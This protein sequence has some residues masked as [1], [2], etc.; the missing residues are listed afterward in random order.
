MAEEWRIGGMAEWWNGGNGRMAE[1]RKWQKW[2]EWWNGLQKYL[3]GNSIGTTNVAEW[4]KEW[5]NGGMVEWRD[6][7]LPTTF[8]VHANNNDDDNNGNDRLRHGRQ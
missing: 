7:Y 1:W 3:R 4:Q 8:M 2:W 6:G 5:S